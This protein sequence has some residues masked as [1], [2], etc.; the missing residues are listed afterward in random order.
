MDVERKKKNADNTPYDISAIC[1]AL[2]SLFDAV[3]KKDL[4]AKTLRVEKNEKVI[5]LE[6]VTNLQNGNFNLTF[7][8]G[9]YN[10]S[11]EV[12]NT[13]TMEDLGIKL[14]PE[15]APKE[16]THLC[17]RLL[18][19]ADR[20]TAVLES[21][22]SGVSISSIKNYLN[23]Q[24]NSIQED[25]EDNYSYNVSFEIMLGEDFLAELDKMNKINIMRITVDIADLGKDFQNFAGRDVRS[26]VELYIRKEQGRGKNIPK[27]IISTAYKQHTDVQPNLRIKKIAVE[28]GN[29]NGNL[30][31]DTESIH[32]KHSISVKTTLPTNEVSSSDFFT[33]ADAFIR[34]MGV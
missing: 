11:R 26:T 16:K 15:D 18:K 1:T 17:I 30:K 12:V 32:M 22:S 6:S 4:Q 19:G 14:N 33:K 3:V 28:G 21:N 25:S 20:F 23:N 9:K 27:D 8:S 7:R 5:W 2:S 10:Q 34:E 24:F 31:I 29:I 13:D